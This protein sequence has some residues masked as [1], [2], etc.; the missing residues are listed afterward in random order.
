MMSSSSAIQRSMG[1]KTPSLMYAKIM[2]AQA[3]NIP[4]V[5]PWR[6][7]TVNACSRLRWRSACRLAIHPRQKSS[8]GCSAKIA[9]GTPSSHSSRVWA[10][11]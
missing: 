5:S 6:R 8:H 9:A 11:P 4:V 2:P 1:T 3:R 10:R 7:K